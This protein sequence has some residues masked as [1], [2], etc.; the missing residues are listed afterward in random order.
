MNKLIG[1]MAALIFSFSILPVNAGVIWSVNNHEYQ[2][3]DA[4]LISW[5]DAL[6]A[7]AAMGGGWHLATITSADEHAFVVANLL[8]PITGAS[9]PR[10]HYWIGANDVANEGSF[11]WVTGE[12][13]SFTAWWGGEPNNAGDEDY[14]AYDLRGTDWR[15]NDATVNIAG[16]D[17]GRGY[18]IERTVARVSE[19]ATLGLFAFGA[20]V[21]TLR[22]RAKATS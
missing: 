5:T 22:K 20:L 18:L 17:F 6:A 21:L 15:W 10:A 12:A 19:P 1:I 3:M 4:S 9:D 11:A 7:T 14:L 16:F 2:R 13:F 8:A